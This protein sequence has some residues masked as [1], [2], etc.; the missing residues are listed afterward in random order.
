M[1]GLRDVFEPMAVAGVGGTARLRTP[2]ATTEAIVADL[3]VLRRL[4]TAAHVPMVPL[5]TTISDFHELSD[6]PFRIAERETF[7]I[8]SARGGDRGTLPVARVAG[9]FIGPNGR[10][11]SPVALHRYVAHILEG[12]FVDGEND[13]AVIEEPIRAA[14]LFQHVGAAGALR[15]R[16]GTRGGVPVTAELHPLDAAAASEA[17]PAAGAVV[18]GLDSETG[19]VQRFW[20]RASVG[21]AHPPTI[22]ALLGRSVR[23]WS[24]ICSAVSR[25]AKAVGLPEL[26]IDL[27]VD[28]SRGPLVVAVAAVPAMAL[29]V[30]ALHPRPRTDAMSSRLA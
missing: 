24:V 17:P 18:L 25:A 3:R 8:R 5:V 14:S 6:L 13:G 15:V 16:V 20:H 28:P 11:M 7:V 19:E 26:A 4:L 2:L 30:T 21:A 12:A 23:G 22:G 29:P 27:V 9:G 10:P 1:S